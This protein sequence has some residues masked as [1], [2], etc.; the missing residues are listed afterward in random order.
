MGALKKNDCRRLKKSRRAVSCDLLPRKKQLKKQKR[1][2]L[3]K[4]TTLCSLAQRWAFLQRLLTQPPISFIMPSKNFFCT[5]I[6][7]CRRPCLPACPE[8]RLA[9]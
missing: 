3:P 4:P 9:A 5:A 6:I 7:V 1:S 2:S 8:F